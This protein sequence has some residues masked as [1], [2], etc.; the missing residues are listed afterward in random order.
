M[1][2]NFY[3]TLTGQDE[4]VSLHIGKRSGAGGGLC[5]FGL[6][7]HHLDAPLESWAQ[8]KRLLRLPGVMVSDEYGTEH[9]VEDFIAEVEATTPENRSRQYD[10]VQANRHRDGYSFMEFDDWLCPDGF[11]FTFK[12][13]S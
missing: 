3:A 11:S 6:Q 2:T 4:P 13:F 12:D 10:W 5:S 7:G 9:D 8:W 1:G